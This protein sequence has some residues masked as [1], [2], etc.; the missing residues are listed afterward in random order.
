MNSVDSMIDKIHKKAIHKTDEE[1]TVNKDV[2]YNILE[3]LA[4]EEYESGFT[5]GYFQICEENA[6]NEQLQRDLDG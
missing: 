4:R 3:N 1:V 5:H 2:L 6:Q